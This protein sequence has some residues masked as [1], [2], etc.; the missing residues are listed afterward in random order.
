MTE[1]TEEPGV[2][3]AKRRAS[4]APDAGSADKP[5]E[6]A[7]DSEAASLENAPLRVPRRGRRSRPQR[8]PALIV[9]A[10]LVGA[11]VF[12]ALRGMQLVVARA[13][14]TPVPAAISTPAPTSNQGPPSPTPQPTPMPTSS[15]LILE[16]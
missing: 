3:P 9:A 13:P 12:L 15:A 7:L 8:V 5:A 11:G 4:E 6:E 2:D 16:P 1:Q 14:A 10:V